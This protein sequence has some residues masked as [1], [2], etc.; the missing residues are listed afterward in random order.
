[1][2]E[3]YSFGEII[4]DG[5]TFNSDIIIFPDGRIEDSW[6]RENGHSLSMK[7]IKELVESHPEIIIAG[8]GDSGCMLPE[9][10]MEET[11]LKKG[12]EFKALCTKEACRIFNEICAQKRV[13]ACFHLTC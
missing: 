6:W 2:I 1:M 8:T 13:G 9:K 11:L 5:E 12:I 10:D 4:I 3:S 7:D